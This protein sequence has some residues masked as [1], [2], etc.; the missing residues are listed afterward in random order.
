MSWASDDLASVII[1]PDLE[2]AGWGQGVIEAWNPDTFENRVQYRGSQHENLPVSTGVEALTYQPGDVVMLSRWQPTGGGATTLRIGAGG[3]VIVPGTGAAE[4]AI[5]F[6]R[7]SLVR[8]LS[9]EVFDAQVHSDAV[10]TLETRASANY[11]DLATPGPTVSDVQIV[12]GRAIVFLGAGV[13]SLVTP[14]T[15][16]PFMSMQVTGPT[17]IDPTD[18]FPIS[19]SHG[20]RH[21][22]AGFMVYRLTLDP[23]T[24]TFQAKYR[25]S[26][27]GTVQFVNR[28]MV[29]IAL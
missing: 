22:H 27:G 7:T 3:R 2:F 9:A 15:T 13:G 29:V 23:G 1:R 25:S 17:S 10:E 26:D 11:G 4:K 21:T 28:Q 8:A 16:N 12:I 19:F 6:M 24:Y 20:T 14:T 5:A 18:L